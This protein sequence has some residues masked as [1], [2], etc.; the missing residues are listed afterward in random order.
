[1]SYYLTGNPDIDFYNEKSIDSFLPGTERLIKEVF[2]DEFEN[3]YVLDNDGIL[4]LYINEY[5]QPFPIVIPNIKYCFHLSDYYFIHSDL[6]VH[7]FD[8]HLNELSGSCRILGNDVHRIAYDESSKCIIIFESTEVKYYYLGPL[9]HL[10]KTKY[11]PL[12]HETIS[13]KY[14]YIDNYPLINLDSVESLPN[15]FLLQNASMQGNKY[16]RMHFTKINQSEE[17][18]KLESIHTII[19]EKSIDYSLINN[20]APSIDNEFDSKFNNPNEITIDIDPN[21]PVYDQSVG[22]IPN[23]Y[24]TNNVL[25]FRFEQVDAYYNVTSY[26]DGVTRHVFRQL[27]KEIDNLLK[28]QIENLSEKDSFN[29]GKMIYFCAFNGNELFSQLNPYFF[30]LLSKE[31]DYFN[32]LTTFKG[33]NCKQYMELYIKYK[34]NPEELI[35]LDIGLNNHLEYMKFLFESSLSDKL[36]TNYQNIVNGF[37]LNLKRNKLFGIIGKLPLIGLIHS[38]VVDE[39]F[40]AKLTFHKDDKKFISEKNFDIYTD[41]FQ[42]ILDEFTTTEKIIFLQ[43]I[44]GSS[45]YNGIVKIIFSYEQ[46]EMN[47]TQ[48][49]YDE[50]TIIDEDNENDVNPET[51][52]VIINLNTLNKENNQPSYQI[53]TCFSELTIYLEPTEENLRQIMNVLILEDVGLK[54]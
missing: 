26:G 54:N 11:Y 18:S 41:T 32:L 34:S 10:N 35:K 37:L 24:R 25:I 17:L 22:I 7:V 52:N 30:Y 44:T 33:D 42:K 53:S 50:D 3:V 39:Y 6:K 27:R 9:I 1:M 15:I 47:T 46:T 38:L 28:D 19:P 40:E 48:T 8:K 14:C 31:S 29:L 23:L 45:Y 36:I 16:T 12:F 13:T 20:L 21:K 51:L 43:N 5:Y 2:T 4:F 49:I